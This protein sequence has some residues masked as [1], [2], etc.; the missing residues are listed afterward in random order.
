MMRE[1]RENAASTNVNIAGNA[2][3][4]GVFAIHGE[5]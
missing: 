4:D 2:I 5:R 1:V 3:T